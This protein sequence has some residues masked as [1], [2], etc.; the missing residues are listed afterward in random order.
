MA[1][2]NERNIRFQA[3][4]EE[5]FAR[6]KQLLDTDKV[7][8]DFFTDQSQ[9]SD[10]EKMEINQCF[11]DI[12]SIFDAPVKTPEMLYQYT[13]LRMKLTWH[14]LPRENVCQCDL[15]N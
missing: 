3:A 15:C 6:P 4:C 1:S 12:K 9:Y 2:W 14:L 5:F 11:V 7:E 8:W 13:N 10:L